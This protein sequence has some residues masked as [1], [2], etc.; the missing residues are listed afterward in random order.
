ME[1]AAEW[2]LRFHSVLGLKQINRKSYSS[3]GKQIISK[4]LFLTGF[5]LP[6]LLKYVAGNTFATTFLINM[7]NLLM[8]GV[9]LQEP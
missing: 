8:I 4:C 7:I 1:I 6:E 9:P 3:G 2:I 5:N